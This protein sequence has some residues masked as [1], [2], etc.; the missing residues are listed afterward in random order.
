ME[1]PPPTTPV[2][3]RKTITP[4]PRVARDWLNLAK[5]E[6]FLSL[7]LQLLKQENIN[8]LQEYLEMQFLARF[9]QHRKPKGPPLSLQLDLV[10]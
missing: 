2:G 3:P 4:K 9:R 6:A 7:Q 1:K 5:Y 8:S 10:N